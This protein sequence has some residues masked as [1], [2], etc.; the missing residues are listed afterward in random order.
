MLA[1]RTSFLH[2]FDASV[3][4]PQW[5]TLRETL[6]DNVIHTLQMKNL[7]LRETKQFIPDHTVVGGRA[8]HQHSSLYAGSHPLA[9]SERCFKLGTLR[10]PNK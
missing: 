5:P 9:Y 1:F 4:G 7:R 10:S 3:P 2:D 6:F 8:E